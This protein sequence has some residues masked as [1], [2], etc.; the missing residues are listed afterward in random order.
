MK[1]VLSFVITALVILLD[2]YCVSAAESALRTT[3]Y[4][5]GECSSW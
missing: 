2:A 1:K 3:Y 5:E 4:I